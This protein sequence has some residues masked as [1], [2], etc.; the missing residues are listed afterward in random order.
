[1]AG[2]SSDAVRCAGIRAPRTRA[3]ATQ[4]S[5]PLTTEK[6]SPANLATAPASTFPAEGALLTAQC[7]LRSGS[8]GFDELGRVE[9]PE[10][11]QR[12][13]LAGPVAAVGVDAIHNGD[14]LAAG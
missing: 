4:A 3:P 2:A 8:S 1:V 12:D 13:E 7:Q 14:V 10:C 6:S 11:A 9:L 5:P